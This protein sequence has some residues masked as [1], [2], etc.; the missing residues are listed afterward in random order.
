M[1]ESIFKKLEKEVSGENARSYNVDIAQHHRVQASPG[2]RRAADYCVNAFKAG[3]LGDA[4]RVDYPA[5]DLA[6]YGCFKV[7]GEWEIEE[8]EAQRLVPLMG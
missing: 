4:V 5:T 2:S 3:G 7:F 8:A 6:K 1:F